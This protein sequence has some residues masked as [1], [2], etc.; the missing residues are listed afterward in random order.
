MLNQQQSCRRLPRLILFLAGLLYLMGTV[1]DPLVH[2]GSLAAPVGVA[3][4]VDGE[5]DEAEETDA[6]ALHDESQCLLCKIG[7]SVGVAAAAPPVPERS[8]Y[9][10]GSFPPSELIR[11]PPASSSSQPRAPPHA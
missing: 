5:G 8:F 9:T 6:D 3:L 4:Q 11:A 1:A 7:R 2:A 10:A